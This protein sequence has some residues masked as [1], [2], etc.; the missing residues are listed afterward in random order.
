M[1]IFLYLSLA[2]SD[3]IA[4]GCSKQLLAERPAKDLY[5]LLINGL[6]RIA[7]IEQEVL[8]KVEFSS[9]S[10]PTTLLTRQLS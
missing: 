1:L 4:A 7:T 9:A 6:H 10:H 3:L 5:A 2:A 8:P